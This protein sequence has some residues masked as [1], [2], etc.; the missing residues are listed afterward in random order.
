MITHSRPEAAVYGVSDESIV[1]PGRG[2]S[3]SRT[4]LL[5]LDQD[6]LSSLRGDNQY[7]E[8]DLVSECST[9][10]AYSPGRFL[11]LCDVRDD[12][13]LKDDVTIWPVSLG[14]SLGD[15]HTTRL[16][17]DQCKISVSETF[18]HSKPMHPA[19]RP[20]LR[21]PR[22]LLPLLLC[23]FLALSMLGVLMTII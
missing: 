10:C 16:L 5:H 23:L 17:A 21:S 22:F 18:L 6:E 8:I 1:R 11:Q 9:P 3:L 12:A 4:T 7:D 20:T 15:G 2:L 19:R 13:D 14:P